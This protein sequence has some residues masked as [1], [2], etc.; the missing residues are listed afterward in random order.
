MFRIT[1]KKADAKQQMPRGLKVV[2]PPKSRKLRRLMEG[3][4]I[5][6]SGG[7]RNV[8]TLTSAALF[9]RPAGMPR[10]RERLTAE[11]RLGDRR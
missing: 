8:G 11:C 4:D 1:R 9:P 2:S 5:T 6:A 3:R 10:R 7:C